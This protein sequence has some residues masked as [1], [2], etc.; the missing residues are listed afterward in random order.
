MDGLYVRH[1]MKFTSGIWRFRDSTREHDGYL[2][3]DAESGRIVPVT[4]SRMGERYRY[5]G[6][7]LWF[8][9]FGGFEIA[10]T[11]IK[12]SGPHKWM[13]EYYR[14]DENWMQWS[15]LRADIFHELAVKEEVPQD[16]WKEFQRV[17][18]KS[19]GMIKPAYVYT[20]QSH[21]SQNSGEQ[22]GTSNG[23]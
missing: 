13:H 12:S 14:I 5:F 2:F 21:Q 4:Y 17:M 3:V 16:Y 22:D 10:T 18:L 8:Y 11:P 19:N 23:G 9:D 15:N 7:G 20:N 6:Y 1:K